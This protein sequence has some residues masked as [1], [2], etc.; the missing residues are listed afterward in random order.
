MD[1][2]CHQKHGRLAPRAGAAVEFAITAGLRRQF[3]SVRGFVRA[4]HAYMR[5]F[6]LTHPAE[7][8]RIPTRRCVDIARALTQARSRRAAELQ[9]AYLR[10]QARGETPADGSV[11]VL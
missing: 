8:G 4:L 1:S 6:A 5:A 2:C 10:S 9:A 7:C 11:T 3:N